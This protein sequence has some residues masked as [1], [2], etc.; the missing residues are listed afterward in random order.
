MLASQQCPS[1]PSLRIMHSDFQFLHVVGYAAMWILIPADTFI[2]LADLEERCFSER[3]ATFLVV[4]AVP[5]L[6]V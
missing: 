1:L 2:I 5:M 3:H 6:I 4:V